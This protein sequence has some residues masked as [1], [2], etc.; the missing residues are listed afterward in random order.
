MIRF[1]FSNPRRLR[2]LGHSSGNGLKSREHNESIHDKPCH[3]KRMRIKMSFVTEGMKG[4]EWLWCG[5][6]TSGQ[7][8]SNH[9]MGREQLKGEH[10]YSGNVIMQRIKL[11][12]SLEVL[13]AAVCFTAFMWNNFWWPCSPLRVLVNS[14]LSKSPI[15]VG[16]GGSDPSDSV[17]VWYEIWSLRSQ[18]ESS[19][20]CSSS[21]LSSIGP[22]AH[23]KQVYTDSDI[24]VDRRL[25][26][27]YIICYIVMAWAPGCPHHL[28]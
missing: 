7:D 22:S 20:P 3:G 24:P 15:R 25:K 17:R 6:D 21:Y 19:G 23:T 8:W 12:M 18:H 26:C 5:P 9:G 2:A 10:S 28:P 11:A 14:V 13:H 16:K 27:F 4:T 1:W